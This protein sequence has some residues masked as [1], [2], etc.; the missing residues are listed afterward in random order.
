MPRILRH[1]HVHKVPAEGEEGREKG[2]KR[3]SQTSTRSWNYFLFYRFG[4]PQEQQRESAVNI[5][6]N[7]TL[8]RCLSYYLPMKL[9]AKDEIGTGFWDDEDK[10]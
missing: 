3:G 1:G 2:E 6:L 5:F 8:E 10:A 7:S 4:N 9:R